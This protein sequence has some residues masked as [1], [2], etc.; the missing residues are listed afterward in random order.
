MLVKLTNF[1]MGSIDLL[2]FFLT[3]PKHGKPLQLEILFKIEKKLH[4]LKQQNYNISLYKIK[5]KSKQVVD[6]LF[7]KKKG[8]K[9]E[10]KALFAER[11][12]QFSVSKC[13]KLHKGLFQQMATLVNICNLMKHCPKPEVRRCVPINPKP[14]ST[15][16]AKRTF[17]EQMHTGLS[18]A[19]FFLSSMSMV[20]R[21]SISNK[22]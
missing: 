15:F 1:D 10:L 17:K 6:V 16:Y 21:R 22:Q 7:E 13:S 12:T 11:L 14:L 18:G 20:F 3:R 4:S 19:H 8:S 5:S 9:N 2:L